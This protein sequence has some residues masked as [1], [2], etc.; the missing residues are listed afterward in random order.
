MFDFLDSE[1]MEILRRAINARCKDLNIRSDSSE[2]E[3]VASQLIELFQNGVTDEQE[4]ITRPIA[5]ELI[6]WGK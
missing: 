5:I 2:A 1:D 6:L 4:L 3:M